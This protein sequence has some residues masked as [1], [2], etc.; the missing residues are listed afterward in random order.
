MDDQNTEKNRTPHN[1][2]VVFNDGGFFKWAS[3]RDESHFKEECGYLKDY[4][5]EDA[6]GITP[7]RAS[8]ICIEHNSIEQNSNKTLADVLSRLG[9]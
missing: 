4:I 1:Y 7:E 3:F 6:K 2:A 8:E 5:F 9:F